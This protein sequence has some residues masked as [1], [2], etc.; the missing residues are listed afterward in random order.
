M[1]TLTRLLTFLALLVGAVYAVMAALVAFVEPQ[2]VPVTVKV[3]I[4]A[5]QPAPVAPNTQ[6]GVAP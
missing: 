1:P 6:T 4:P 3:P 5:L 2:P